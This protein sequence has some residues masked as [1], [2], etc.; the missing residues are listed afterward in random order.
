MLVWVSAGFFTK[1]FIENSSIPCY[2][3]SWLFCFLVNQKTIQGRTSKLFRNNSKL[4]T[5]RF[6]NK[7]IVRCYLNTIYYEIYQLKKH[8]YQLRKIFSHRWLS[9]FE[10]KV[11][12]KI[13]AFT[14]KSAIIY[15]I[16]RCFT[17]NH[18]MNNQ[19]RN[20][21][22]FS[23]SDTVLAFFSLLPLTGSAT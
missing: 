21:E 7:K 2:S 20:L 23:A 19:S 12:M 9:S 18:L 13:I 15:N 1:V 10:Q 5:K 3:F 8:G 6:V 16:K 17:F 11:D 14:Y 4:K 22:Y